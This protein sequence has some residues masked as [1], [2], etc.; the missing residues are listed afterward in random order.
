MQV[1]IL[2]FIYVLDHVGI[3]TARVRPGPYGVY[4]YGIIVR[5]WANRTSF[6]E[7]KARI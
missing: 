2:W 6:D 5:V 3:Q 4:S 1:N 7:T